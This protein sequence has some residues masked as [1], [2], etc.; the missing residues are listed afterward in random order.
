MIKTLKLTSKRQATFPAALCEE[1]GVS[2]G[3]ELKLERHI[4]NGEAS[5]VIQA[6]E[7]PGTPWFGALRDYATDKPH[8][9]KSIRTTIGQKVGYRKS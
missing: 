3:D 1:L 8:D 7:K 6:K 5:W 2:P 4:L 9:M